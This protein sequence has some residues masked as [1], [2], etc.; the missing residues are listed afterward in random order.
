MQMTL[1]S[2]LLAAA[3]SFAAALSSSNAFAASTVQFNGVGSSAMFNTFGLAAIASTKCGTNFWSKKSTATG[4]DNR[5]TSSIPAESGNVWISW[6]TD[7]SGNVTNICAYLSVDSIVGDRLFMAAPRGTLSIPSTNVGLAGDNLVPTITDIPLS[8]NAYNAINNATFNAG[9]SDIRLEDAKF[10]TA[11]ALAALDTV[12]Y[13]G[14]GYGPGPI[15]TAI[16]SAF[17]TKSAQVVDFAITGADPISGQTVKTYVETNVGAEP[18][19]VFVNTNDTDAGHL[20]NSAY[21]NVDRFVLTQA[22]NG[23]ITRTRDLI[24]STGLATAALHVLEREPMSGTYNTFEFN[25]PR[26]KEVNSTQEVG[27]NPA[28]GGNPLNI[29]YAS[30]GSRQRV[31]G[32]GEM[33]SEVSAITDSLGYAFWST[34]NFAKVVSNT[35][36][37]TVDGVDP[38]FANYAGGTFPTCIAPC[39]GLVDFTNVI[40][41][42]Y[43]AWTILRVMTDTVIPTGVSA[44][45]TSAQ[46]QA[47]NIPDFVP[48]ASM[49]VF[50]SHYLQSGAAPQN[51]HKAG[52]KE[53]G[54]DVGGAVFTVQADLDVIT[55]TGKELTGFK[56]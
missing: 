9:M 44:L 30:G 42:S 18:V 2:K 20:G 8:Q 43:P 34:G 51:G 36:Y 49:Q 32:T 15:G 23:G 33:T 7:T 56:Q 41:G 27:V 17:S 6:A 53:K 55:D 13:N 31:I 19:V 5:N 26:S 21:Q 4:V 48:L 47:V 1:R 22:F 24:P 40:N 50:R 39:P 16:L 14:L 54:G 37:L 3:L 29:A 45:I 28:A 12:A 38:L 52:Q 25:V 35:K 11:R 46:T 10:A